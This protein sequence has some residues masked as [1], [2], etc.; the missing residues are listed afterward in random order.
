ML[1]ST[2]TTED[3]EHR[4]W[5]QDRV[6]SRVLGHWDIE[7]SD[8]E[9]DT[10]FLLVPLRLAHRDVRLAPNRVRLVINGINLASQ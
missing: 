8:D 1:F 10:V 4:E 9:S 5:P 6:Q 2:S 7:Y 3:K